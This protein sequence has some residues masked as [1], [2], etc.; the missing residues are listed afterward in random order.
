MELPVQRMSCSWNNRKVLFPWTAS[1]VLGQ[2]YGVVFV[3]LRATGTCNSGW[4]WA[5]LW[6]QVCAGRNWS[7]VFVWSFLLII[8]HESADKSQ[9]Q[10]FLPDLQQEITCLWGCGVTNTRWPALKCII[11][12]YTRN[13]SSV[14]NKQSTN[15]NH[16]GGCHLPQLYIHAYNYLI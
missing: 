10:P 12:I 3:P 6:F 9:L 15:Q 4:H 8:K 1:V 7:L 16:Y 2:R 13:K 11:E 14:W 5:K